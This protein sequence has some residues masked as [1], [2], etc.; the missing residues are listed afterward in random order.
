[1]ISRIYFAKYRVLCLF[2]IYGLREY[3]FGSSTH[4]YDFYPEQINWN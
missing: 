4:S 1:L 2:K 3:E